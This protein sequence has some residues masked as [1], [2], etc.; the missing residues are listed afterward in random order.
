MMLKIFLLFKTQTLK[1]E[2]EYTVNFWMMIF[3][4][5]I[6]R[7]LIMAVVFVLFR[8]IPDI[9]GWQEG[10]I[11]LLLGFI[12]ITEG[13]NSMLF[14]GI[15]FIP[16]WVFRGGFDVMISRPVSPLFQ[17]LSQEI[18]LHGI[19]TTII[20]AISISLG[21]VMMGWFNPLSIILCLFFVFAGTVLRM[22]YNLITLSHAFWIHGGL[23][24]VGFLVH[25]VGEFARYP[26]TIYPGWMRFI[27]LFIIPAGFIGFVPVM[28][29]RGDNV[30]L[31]GFGLIV[32]TSLYFLLAR[33]VF[34]RGIKRYESIGM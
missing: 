13:I 32:M 2:M 31:Y 11:Y 27:L 21:L 9:A 4:G 5:I 15:W 30:L 6:M 22:S 20:G 16:S 3:S 7:G 1:T 26:I 12:I 14:D 19:G 10:E 24:N 29:L 34:Y 33:T 18:G 28:I 23:A 25:S 17:V 8:N